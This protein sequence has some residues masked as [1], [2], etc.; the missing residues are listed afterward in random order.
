MARSVSTRT[1][2][3]PRRSGRVLGASSLTM[4]RAAVIT[5]LREQ[6]W[7]VEAQAG[8]PF[9]LPATIANRYPRLPD[10]LVEFLSGLK[11]CVDR[12]QTTWFLCQCDYE[13]TSG[14]AFR[15]DE[16]EQLSLDSARGDADYIAEIRAFWDSHFPILFSVHSG[17]AYHAVCTASDRFGQVVEGFEPAFEEVLPVADSFE[18]FIT[19]F[20]DA[21]RST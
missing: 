5:Q 17:Y 7:T 15:W 20:T 12:S 18:S 19:T 8:Q 3:A 14:S 2:S 9:R 16:W 4:N 11:Q 10:S 21:R 1:S 13:G 6:G